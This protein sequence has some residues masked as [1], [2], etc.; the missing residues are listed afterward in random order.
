MPNYD[1]DSYTC[2]CPSTYTGVNCETAFASP[3]SAE[4]PTTAPET[5]TA[6]APATTTTPAPV[7]T[8]EEETVTTEEEETITT[9][10]ETITTDDDESMTTTI[11]PGKSYL[12]LSLD[13]YIYHFGFSKRKESQTLEFSLK[14]VEIFF[15]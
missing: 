2:H 14:L 10:E 5:N 3:A 9:E 7:I 8:T 12:T 4:P 13:Q 1:T 6:P 11:T 15:K